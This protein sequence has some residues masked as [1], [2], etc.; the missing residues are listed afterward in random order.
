VASL[1]SRYDIQA[2]E[3]IIGTVE[4]Q[5]MMAENNKSGSMIM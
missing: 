3:R 4:A 5:Q 2:L 1:C